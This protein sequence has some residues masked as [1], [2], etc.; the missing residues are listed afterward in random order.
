MMYRT[1]PEVRKVLDDVIFEHH[2]DLGGDEPT[3]E[4][5]MLDKTPKTGGHEILGRVS[6]VMGLHGWLAAGERS[7]AFDEN[8]LFVMEIPVARWI[9][10]TPA[11]QEALVDHLASHVQYHEETDNWR[12]VKPE[13]GEFPWIVERRGFWRPDDTLGRLATKMAEQLQLL[14]A[15][16]QERLALPIEDVEGGGDP[17]ERTGQDALDDGDGS[18]AETPSLAGAGVS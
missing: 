17:A 6:K 9:D 8:A 5:V 3:I 12:V 15:E 16:D 1:A 14:P 11:Q 13:F 10:L 4:C 18:G 2:P 7:G